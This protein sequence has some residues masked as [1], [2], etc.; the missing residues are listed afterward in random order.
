MWSIGTCLYELFTSQ[1][2][3]SGRNNNDMVRVFQEIFGRFTN[4]MIKAHLRAYHAL[5]ME[6]HFTPDLI[7]KHAVIDPV[8]HHPVVRLVDVPATPPV[9]FSQ[10]IMDGRAGSD[11]KNKV[12]L[13][14][15][16]LISAL[17]LD[18]QKRITV[19]HARLHPFFQ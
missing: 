4:K 2:L 14:C 16:F 17:N 8:S 19:D 9:D 1:V 12:K 7:F 15:D 18:P 5:E 13:V 3:F 11:D 6:P 10:N